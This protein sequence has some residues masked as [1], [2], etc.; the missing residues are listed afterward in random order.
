MAKSDFAAEHA[1]IKFLGF[2]E[3]AALESYVAQTFA[4]HVFV[5]VFAKF[6]VFNLTRGPRPL[7]PK[8]SFKEERSLLV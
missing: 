7:Q 2:F 4:C 6:V 8:S 5:S 3:I 1:D